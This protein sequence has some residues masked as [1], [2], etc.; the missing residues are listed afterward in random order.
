MFKPVF[1]ELITRLKYFIPWLPY[2]ERFRFYE[3]ETDILYRSAQPTPEALSYFVKKYGINSLIILLKHAENWEFNWASAHNLVV[4][5]IPISSRAP[6]DDE[7]KMF[8][9]F[10]SQ[11]FNQPVLVHCAQ[12]RDRTGCFCFLYR[13]ETMGWG[14]KNAWR[15]M[16]K[17]GYCS[18]PWHKWTMG[19]IRE[20][21][22][23][24][25]G[26]LTG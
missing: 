4:L 14:V 5:Q 17:L 19:F 22:E 11:K 2:E 26:P 6:S 16:K 25:Y 18:L 15:E 10:V 21:L 23:K 1:R 12:G 3:I 7:T 9:K 13:V 8:V 24:K 20:W